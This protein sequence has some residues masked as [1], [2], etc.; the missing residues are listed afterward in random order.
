MFHPRTAHA[1]QKRQT[2]GAMP[3]S[4]PSQG[5]VEKKNTTIFQERTTSP[6]PPSPLNESK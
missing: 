3:V 1:P 6:H 4:S 2:A 5:V